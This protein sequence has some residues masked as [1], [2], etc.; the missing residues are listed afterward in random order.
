MY[1]HTI[2]FLPKIIFLGPQEFFLNNPAFSVQ[3]R[4]SFSENVS[5][6]SRLSS[7]LDFKFIKKIV[8]RLLK[9]S[10]LMSISHFLC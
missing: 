1:L 9:I 3:Y 7:F 5:A 10:W 8:F 6:H 4:D 2:W